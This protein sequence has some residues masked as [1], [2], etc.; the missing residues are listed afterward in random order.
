[1]DY[2]NLNNKFSEKYN[3]FRT[4]S[5]AENPYLPRINKYSINDLIHLEET[6]RESLKQKS[7]KILKDALDLCISKKK[8]LKSKMYEK[9]N[10]E[11]SMEIDGK[12]EKHIKESADSLSENSLLKNL[13]NILSE[14]S[15]PSGS[16]KKFSEDPKAKASFKKRYGKDW[17]PKLYAT[18]WKM[19]KKKKVQEEVSLDEAKKTKEKFAHIR[20]KKIKVTQGLYN[21]KGRKPSDR[22]RAKGVGSGGSV[23]DAP[24]YKKRRPVGKGPDEKKYKSLD[25]SQRRKQAK[26]NKEAGVKVSKSKER[27]KGMHFKGSNELAAVRFWNYRKANPKYRGDP[28]QT[29]ASAKI[30]DGDIKGRFVRYYGAK[31]QKSRNKKPASAIRA[32]IARLIAQGKWPSDNAR[33][34]LAKGRQKRWSNKKP[35]SK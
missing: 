4:K 12:F 24:E 33:K 15:P 22:I 3:L 5:L 34:A 28:K 11:T 32:A 10:K 27:H 7:S 26:K 9:Y 21:N 16:A 35:A 8:E 13:L 17:K 14:S 19:F 6:I 30:K 25:I 2:S 20:G 18:A 31:G 23:L 1:M 29:G